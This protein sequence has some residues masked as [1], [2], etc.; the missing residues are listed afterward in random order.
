M[1]TYELVPYLYLGMKD[2]DIAIQPSAWQVFMIDF[3]CSFSCQSSIFIL[4]RVLCSSLCNQI[5]Q[6]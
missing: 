1:E 5:L 3:I 6:N 4:S 2:R